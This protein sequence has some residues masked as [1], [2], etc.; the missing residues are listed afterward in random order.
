[1]SITTNSLAHYKVISDGKLPEDVRDEILDCCKGND[2]ATL[3]NPD[4]WPKFK[5]WLIENNA[6]VECYLIWWS[7]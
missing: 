7:W 4:Y 2:C 5:Q 1:M 3:V 6:E